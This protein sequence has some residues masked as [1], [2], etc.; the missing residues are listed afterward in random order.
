[1]ECLVARSRPS[2]KAPE[3]AEGSLDLAP[4]VIGGEMKI[5]RSSP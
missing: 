1:M 5:V 3:R 2:D 4:T